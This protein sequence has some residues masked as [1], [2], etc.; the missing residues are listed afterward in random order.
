MKAVRDRG[1]TIESRITGRHSVQVAAAEQVFASKAPDLVLLSVKS[2]DTEESARSL[3]EFIGPATVVLCLQ[4][5]I[6]NHEVA[7]QILGQHRVHPAVIYVGV[8][9]IDAGVIEHVSRGEIILPA[10]LSLLVPVFQDAGVPAKTSDNI[11]GMV[12]NKLLLNASC[13]ALGMISG[14]SFGELA[15][16]AEAVEVI[17]GAV[18]EVIRLA[19]AKGVQIPGENLAEQILKTAESLGSGLSSM[20]QDYR[21]GKRIEIDALNGVVVRMGKEFG[22]PTPYNATLYAA[23][24]LMQEQIRKRESK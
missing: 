1:L 5:G 14:A 9:I 20:L 13:N 17:R 15:R 4:N 21:A 16:S 3:S 6:D 22:I 12:W 24:K 7:A 19:E 18:G 2:Y 11:L 10:V 23:G 8:R